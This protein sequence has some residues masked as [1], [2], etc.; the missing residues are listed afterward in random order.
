MW[1]TVCVCACVCVW[2]LSAT[3]TLWEIICEQQSPRAGCLSE[4]SQWMT[5]VITDDSPWGLDHQQYLSLSLSFSYPFLSFPLSS[6]LS[7]FSSFSFWS[8]PILSLFLW[9]YSH[10]KVT[11]APIPA[12]FLWTVQITRFS[13]ELVQ[14][15]QLEIKQTLLCI[16]RNFQHTFQCPALDQV[17][18][19]GMHFPTCSHV[20]NFYQHII[21]LSLQLVMQLSYSLQLSFD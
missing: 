10:L 8:Y 16:L 20:N 18:N 21:N 1:M 14:S 13:S 3:A 5:W 4:R 2:G 9:S 12:A 19:I 17:P 7:F 11:L 15:K 6:S